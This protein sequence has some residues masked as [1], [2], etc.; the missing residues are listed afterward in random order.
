VEIIFHG[1]HAHVSD[2]FRRRAELAAERAARRLVRA[3][4]AIVR[5]EQDGPVKRVEIVLHGAR[6]KNIIA[7]GE[8]KFYGSALSVAIDRLERNVGKTKAKPR[9]VAAA[10]RAQPRL[11]AEE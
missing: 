11:V 3:V 4:D 7:R 1:H 5:F 6:H 8:G 2:R 10:S 9:Q